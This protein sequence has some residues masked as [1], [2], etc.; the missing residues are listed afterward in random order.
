MR[1]GK[2]AVGPLVRVAVL[3]P[4]ALAKGVAESVRVMFCVVTVATIVVS[5]PEEK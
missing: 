4:V 1:K 2:G 5:G 3:D